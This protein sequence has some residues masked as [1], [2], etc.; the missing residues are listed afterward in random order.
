MSYFSVNEG[1]RAAVWL[2]RSEN[3]RSILEVC[4]SLAT[5][6]HYETTVF[7]E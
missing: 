5:D 6:V 4:H 2:V 7:D 3:T 1:G